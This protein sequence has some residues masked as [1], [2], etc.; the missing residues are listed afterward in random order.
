VGNKCPSAKLRNEVRRF[1][2]CPAVRRCAAKAANRRG[3]GRLA[4]GRPAVGPAGRALRR[5]L[6][7]N[8]QKVPGRQRPGTTTE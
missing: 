7:S 2:V 5:S 8:E 1:L 6:R 4:S 3:S